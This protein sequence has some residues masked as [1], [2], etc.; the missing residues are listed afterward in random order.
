MKLA[1]TCWL[2]LQAVAKRLSDALGIRYDNLAAIDRALVTGEGKLRVRGETVELGGF[3]ECATERLARAVHTLCNQVGSGLDIDHIV[4]CGGGADLLMPLI[5][6]AFPKHIVEKMP[7]PVMANVRG[8]FLMA[9][10]S[11]NISNEEAAA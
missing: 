2:A 1:T 3:V 9:Q 11:R 5:A 10:S 4:V 7:S 6:Q 8:F